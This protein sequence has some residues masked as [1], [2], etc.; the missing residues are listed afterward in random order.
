MRVGILKD[1]AI[2][3]FQ[4]YGFAKRPCFEV[5]VSNNFFNQLREIHTLSRTRGKTRLK[6]GKYE[7]LSHQRIDSG[8]HFSVSKSY[9]L[10]RQK[11]SCKQKNRGR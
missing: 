9:G 7:N 1:Q 6:A 2:L 11:A 8:Q 5:S 4:T 10:G 3:R